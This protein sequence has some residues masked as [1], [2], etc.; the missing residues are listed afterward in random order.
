[1]F[2]KTLALLTL[3]RSKKDVHLKESGRDLGS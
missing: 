1:L 3:Q 2:Y